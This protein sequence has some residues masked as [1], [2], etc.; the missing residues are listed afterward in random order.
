[1]VQC[2][3]LWDWK[4]YAGLLGKQGKGFFWGKL[5]KKPVENLCYACALMQYWARLYSKG[6]SRE[7]TRR[8]ESVKRHAA[9]GIKTAG[10]SIKHGSGDP[11]KS[12]KL[13]GEKRAGIGKTW[14]QAACHE[15]MLLDWAAAPAFLVFC[16]RLC[17][18]MYVFTWEVW[19]FC[20]ILQTVKLS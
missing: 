17:W 18:R 16:N 2:L 15:S 19:C 10:E 20:F 14:Q 1:M 12:R 8:G 9:G 6:G 13:T 3:T 5:I 7:A 11:A 4:Q